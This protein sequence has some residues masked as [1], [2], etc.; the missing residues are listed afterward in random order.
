MKISHSI[1][2]KNWMLLIKIHTLKIPK[3]ATAGMSA[4]IPHTTDFVV[5]LDYDNIDDERLVDE[6]M[7]LQELFRLGDFYVFATNEYGRHAICI[8]RLGLRYAVK[9]LDNSTCDFIFKKGAVINEFRTWILR[10]LGK[11]DRPKPEFLYLV[12]SPYNGKRLQSQA[13]AKFLQIH[14]QCPV[15]LTNPDGNEELETQ[16][17]KTS[18]KTLLKDVRKK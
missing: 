16:G 10:V 18:S 6:L 14:Y 9:V 5:F 13:H 11:G 8:D 4:R 17:Y 7:Y 1:R 12:Q 3:E 2:L 15:R